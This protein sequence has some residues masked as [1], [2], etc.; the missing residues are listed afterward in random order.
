MPFPAPQAQRK[1]LIEICVLASGSKGNAIYIGAGKTS[2]LID[3]GLAGREIERRMKS[4]DLDPSRINAICVTHEHTDHIRG[5]GVLSRKY[6]IPVFLTQG[7]LKA[8]SGQIGKLPEYVCI[9]CGK[10]FFIDQLTICPFSTSHDAAEPAAYTLVYAGY[11]IGIAMDLG[12]VTNL[13]RHSLAGCNIL[14]LEANHD[15]AMLAQGPY[16][17]HLKQRIKG[18]SGHLSNEAAGKLLSDIASPALS[19]VVLAHIS[20]TNNTPQKALSTVKTSLKGNTPEILTAAQNR[21]TKMIRI[22]PSV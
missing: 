20:E 14:V 5:V 9:D 4:L 18:R 6:S 2:I 13:V 7:T 16:P 21:P 3:A 22:I 17:W 8:A 10:K 15:P 1:T 19:H 12:T 11:R